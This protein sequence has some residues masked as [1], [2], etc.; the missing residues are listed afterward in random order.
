M[1]FCTLIAIA[2]TLLF[3]TTNACNPLTQGGC[4][5]VPALGSSFLETFSDNL[6]SHFESLNKQ[7][8][9]TFSDS[10]G[11]SLT[12]NKR[13]DNPSVKSNFYIMFGRVE[14]VL[15]A[16]QGT[17]IVSSF[18]LQSD[19]LDEIDIELFGG[20]P[21]QWQSNYFVKGN[22]ATYDR[23]GYHDIYN[24]LTTYHKYV[25]DWTE[26]A[27]TWTV[28]GALIRTLPKDNAQGFPQSPMAIYAGIWAGGDPSNE[29]GTIQWAGGITDYS[30]APFTMHIKSILVADYSSG[31]QYSY[32]DQS[33]TWQSI[34]AVNGQVDGRYQQAQ[35]D[36]SKLEAGQPVDQ[37]ND[38]ASTTV[39]QDPTSSSEDPTSSSQD[40]TSSS[41]VSTSSSADPTT[42]SSSSSA[43]P[44]T[45]S[46]EEQST[47]SEES[48]T[49]PTSSSEKPSS[50]SVAASS[51][52]IPSNTKV[53]FIG[54][55]GPES[56]DS[57]ASSASS[58][59]SVATTFI[60]TTGSSTATR[61]ASS[62]LA[63]E[64]NAASD[65]LKTSSFLSLLALVGFLFA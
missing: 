16:A 50:S 21:Y 45:S 7:G 20:D 49:S 37:P 64:N 54:T 1:K 34:K 55:S 8:D 3:T 4:S 32:T 52:S 48:S 38:K 41:E 11:L 42:S 62:V 15:K 18:Y 33:G 28:D 2:S 46:S 58:T 57:V 56:S 40:P 12:M 47:S 51:T 44:T 63:N 27:I 9:I 13:F 14:V 65:A 6:G 10:D 24:P 61:T 5:P 53:V 25:I 35:S 43:D 22:T 31:D 30:Q 29:E 26:D 17:G 23:G 39:S 36:I 59:N 19:D 60:S